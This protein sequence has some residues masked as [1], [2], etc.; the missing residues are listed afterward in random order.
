M[1]YS[2]YQ[3]TNKFNGKKYIGVTDNVSRRWQQHKN[4]KLRRP[5]YLAFEKYGIDNFDFKVI[6]Q[7]KDRE[8]AIKE[9]E[10]LFVKLHNAY[11]SDGYNLNEGGHDTNTPEKRKRSSERM[12]LNNP[13]TGRTNS[14]SFKKGHKPVITAERNKKISESKRGSG[15]PNYGKPETSARLNKRV[16]C[17]H[18]EVE[19]NKGNAT[20]WHFDKCKSKDPIAEFLI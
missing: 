2:I 20:R 5:L 7:S 11:G 19:T 12:R 17:P 4:C 18:C 15:N 16:T 1:I 10:P 6:Y 13:M 14:T 9:A 8:H 3:I